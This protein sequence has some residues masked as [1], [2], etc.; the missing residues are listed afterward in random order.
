MKRSRRKDS[1]D[2]GERALFDWLRATGKA[3][4]MAVLHAYWIVGPIP[5]ASPGFHD[6]LQ[7]GD[8][9]GVN[10]AVRPSEREP[11]REHRGERRR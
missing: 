7:S 2:T 11:E 10:A 8:G 3:V 9:G 5:Y 4:G 6:A 1:A